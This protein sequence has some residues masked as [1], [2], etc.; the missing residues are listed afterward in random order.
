M[1]EE[2][3]DVLPD[4]ELLTK[5]ERETLAEPYLHIV[6]NRRHNWSL[7]VAAL[8]P[9][10]DCFMQLDA[11][12][13]REIQNLS[14]KISNAKEVF[15][16]FLFGV[17]QTK[18]HVVI[19][20]CFSDYIEEAYSILRDAIESVAHACRLLSEPELVEVW[21]ERDKDAASL[22]AW[23]EEFWYAKESRLFEGL[24]DL[25]LFWKFCSD[26]G[27]HTNAQSV[28]NRLEGIDNPADDLSMRY[29]GVSPDA[30]PIVVSGI[31]QILSNL[32]RQIF[33]I[34]SSH[35]QFDED[36]FKMRDRFLGDR[37]TAFEKLGLLTQPTD[38]S[39]RNVGD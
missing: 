32:E 35:L 24:P 15:P 31:L 11:I 38:H 10:W 19:D 22:K 6:T 37:R 8:R 28:F 5:H 34:S 27:S 36:L 26:F 17:A 29:T 9:L 1:N 14:E 13:S 25:Y 7:N 23:K 30:F 2:E 39:T 3:K 12:W 20:L 33:D 16:Y 21:Y 18:I 4:S